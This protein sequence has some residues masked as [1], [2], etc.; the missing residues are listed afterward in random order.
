MLCYFFYFLRVWEK[1]IGKVGEGLNRLLDIYESIIISIVYK[2]MIVDIV[3]F[4]GSL[5]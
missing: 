1:Y 2:V 3:S 5:V 4:W